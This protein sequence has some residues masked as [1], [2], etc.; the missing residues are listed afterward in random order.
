MNV[1]I[2]LLNMNPTLREEVFDL[3][4]ESGIDPAGMLTARLPG[5]D[6]TQTDGTGH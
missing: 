4:A 3:A 2:L 1:W 5:T 6:S